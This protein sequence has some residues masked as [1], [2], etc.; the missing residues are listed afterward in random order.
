MKQVVF[1]VVLLSALACAAQD[2]ALMLRGRVTSEGGG[3]PYATLQLVGTSVGVSCNDAGEYELK[4]PFGCEADTVVVRSVGYETK[5]FAVRD[6]LQRGRVR[7]SQQSVELREVRVKSYRHASQLI[8]DAVARIGSNYHRWSFYGTFFC[9]DWRS[10]DDELYLYDEAVMNIRRTGYQDFADKRVYQF[11][12]GIRELDG[13]SKSLLRHRLL[14]YDRRQIEKALSNRDGVDEMLGYDDNMSFLDPVATPQATYMLAKRIM[15]Y[16]KFESIFEFEWDGDLYYRVRSLGP[17]RLLNAKI[18]YE[19]LIRKSDLAIIRITSSQERI[20][21]LAPQE[22]W[23]N[24]WFT[25][26]TFDADT[27]AWEYDVRDGRYTLT[28]YYNYRHFHLGSKGRGHDGE[29]QDWRQCIDWTMTDFSYDPDS[30]TDHELDVMPQPL[31]GAFGA[32]D[33]SADYWGR[34]NS[35]PIDTLPL[36]LLKDKY[37]KNMSHEKD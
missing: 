19:Y 2:N 21:Q 17:G 3:V 22:A 4:V 31:S 16:H 36:R 25:W 20:G 32:S 9:R 35:I 15:R 18:H 1:I 12:P 30:V 24:P 29:Y 6:L 11:E 13:N 26:L 5:H 14:V 34:Y 28:H 8:K 37:N 10:L 27:S 7:L 23:V 33:Y